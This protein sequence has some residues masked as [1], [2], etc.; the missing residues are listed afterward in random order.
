MPPKDVKLE[1]AT[2][3]TMISHGRELEEALRRLDER[4]FEDW[5]CKMS[6]R[7]IRLVYDAGRPVEIMSVYEQLKRI[8]APEQEKALTTRFMEVVMEHEVEMPLEELVQILVN[9]RKRRELLQISWDLKQLSFDLRLGLETNVTKAVERLNVL[10]TDTSAKDFS[11]LE[12]ELQVALQHIEDNQHRETQHLGILTSIPL[13]DDC[14][15]LPPGLVVVAAK[16]SHGKT[17]FANFLALNAMKSGSKVVY[18]SMEMSNTQL[19]QRLLAME[20]GISANVLAHLKLNVLEKEQAYAGAQRLMDGHAES[21]R[22]DR[23]GVNHLD[24]M[25]QSIRALKQSSGV[26]MVVVDYIQLLGIDPVVR[27]DSTAKRIGHAAHAMHDIGISLGVTIVCLSQLNR[28]ATGLPC[29]AQIRDSGEID[30][31]ADMT[32]LLYRAEADRL[33]SYP[34]PFEEVETEGTALVLL[35]KCRNGATGH[36]VLGF[37]AATTRFKVVEKVERRKVEAVQKEVD[38]ERV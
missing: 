9:F 5:T 21:F 14:G 15:G 10:L 32:I 3:R 12:E 6:F 13:F 35:D 2:V 22:F 24:T 18:Y 36:A 34:M 27:D 33:P 38:W 25:L 11:T 17:S 19:T 20:T 28:N 16:S 29:R 23:R 8:S 26:D 31:A 37:E 1:E 7:A 30:E 4:C